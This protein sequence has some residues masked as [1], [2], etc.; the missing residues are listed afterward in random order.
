MYTNKKSFLK[1]TW[2]NLIKLK[3]STCYIILFTWNVPNEQ[4][5]R[6]RDGFYDFLGL[7]IEGMAIDGHMFSIWR[8]G[9][10]LEFIV[11][12]DASSVNNPKLLGLYTITG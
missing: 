6:D 1:F 5:D 12:M 8:D 4:I 9:N 3:V 10:I 2:I 11:I 7:G